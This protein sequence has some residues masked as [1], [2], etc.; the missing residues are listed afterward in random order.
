MLIRFLQ[1]LKHFF[2]CFVCM[3]QHAYERVYTSETLNTTCRNCMS[4]YLFALDMAHRRRTTTN[5]RVLACGYSFHHDCQT[6]KPTT[7]STKWKVEGY[8]QYC[9]IH[10]KNVKYNRKCAKMVCWVK[11]HFLFTLNH[12]GSLHR[13]CILR[14]N[15]T[16]SKGL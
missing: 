15:V 1:A 16:N 4:I 3:S 5:I 6:I 10:K 13:T 9:N 8:V 14:S 12:L 11:I 2:R 7:A